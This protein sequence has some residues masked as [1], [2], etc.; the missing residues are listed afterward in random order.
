MLKE[1][2]LSNYR[3]IG[4]VHFHPARL[5][6]VVGANGSGKSS[7]MDGLMF[8][9]EAVLHGLSAAITHRGGIQAVRRRSG[10]RPFHMR[11]VAE[12]ELPDGTA[13]YGFTVGGA[14]EA[15]YRV[16]EEDMVITGPQGPV[17]FHRNQDR[18]E[19]SEGLAPRPDAQALA[20]TALTGDTRVR[21]LTDLLAGTM[22]YSIFPDTLREPQKHDAT[23]PMRAHGENWVSTLKA[24]LER[25]QARQDL[26]DALQRATGDI[27]DLR[28]A[29]AAGF[30]VAEFQQSLIPGRTA[31]R[32]AWMSALQQS[33]GTLRIAGI[34]TALLQ[35]PALPL[36][37]L[38]EP[39]LT[40]HPGMIPLIMDYLR[41]A[42]KRS[43]ILLTTHSPLLLDHVDVDQDA[44]Y[45]ARRM[46][47][48]TRI[49]RVSDETLQP[50]R[51][52]LLEL[53]DLY[54]S[55]ALQP[56]LPWSDALP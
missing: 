48:E 6:V 15:E 7:L 50:V 28:T 17:R 55:D 16:L 12:L 53:R 4:D 13:R 52:R 42:S 9:R 49:H 1:L 14:R 19:G 11:V 32:R 18:F 3:S 20:L 46:D 54:E 26:T 41:Q 23:T 38:E 21:A 40:V 37:G 2:Y 36:I 35:E 34:L 39:E 33:D 56:P 8:L 44:I 45:V 27:R 24:L 51:D 22:V 43:Q 10:G 5:S 30:L 25:P 31:D 29:S 47:G